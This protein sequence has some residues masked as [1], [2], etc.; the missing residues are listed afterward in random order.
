MGAGR[1]HAQYWTSLANHNK[2][3]EQLWQWELASNQVDRP[4]EALPLQA[5]QL[6]K[7]RPGERR[8]LCHQFL[9]QQHV[10]TER[11]ATPARATGK[12]AKHTPSTI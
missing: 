8:E 10:P 9:C 12:S 6:D 5:S 11:T 1:L 4:T 7:G 3:T 2:H